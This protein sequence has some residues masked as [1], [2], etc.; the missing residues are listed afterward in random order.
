VAEEYAEKKEVK[1][2]S[3]AQAGKV[4]KFDGPMWME[5]KRNAIAGKVSV[6]ERLR[7]DHTEQE[8]QA[9]EARLDILKQGALDAY[10]SSSCSSASSRSR[11][12]TFTL[13][14]FRQ[15]RLAGA[16]DRARIR[17]GQAMPSFR[18]FQPDD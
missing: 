9:M 1:V 10:R 16:A 11:K 14:P 3:L 18:G 2:V 8:F 12:F 6:R 13:S 15:A 17:P 5:Y 4:A 7:S